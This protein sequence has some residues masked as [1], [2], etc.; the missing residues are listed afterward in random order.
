MSYDAF[1]P[2][3]KNFENRDEFH[4]VLIGKL[5]ALPVAI[6]RATL[7]WYLWRIRHVAGIVEVGGSP[8]HAVHGHAMVFPRWR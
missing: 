5:E 4:V 7:K 6:K 2:Q 1:L 3:S 8:T